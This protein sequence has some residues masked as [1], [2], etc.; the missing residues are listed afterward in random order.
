MAAAAYRGSFTE[1]S[2]NRSCACA[3]VP[4][5]TVHP[6]D[7]V[8]L[9]ASGAARV[10]HIIAPTDFTD[11]SQCGVSAAVN[12]A[13]QLHAEVTLVH[14]YELPG[15]AYYVT[16]DIAAEVEQ[17]ARSRLDRLL[18][19]VRSRIPK[20]EGVLRRGNAWTRILEV[21]KERAGDLVVLST[22]SRH[23]IERVLVGSVADKI[24]R[25]ATVPVL[26]VHP[27]RGVQA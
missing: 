20:V 23:G 4:V 27:T 1:V 5:L 14:I 17:H 10:Q 15:Y 19:D 22:H 2:P 25:L 12:L 7:R 24:V 11:A 9:G 8:P 6:S 16:D 21:A 18:A 26:T 3:L 13:L